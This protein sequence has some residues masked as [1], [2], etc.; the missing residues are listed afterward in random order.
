L[1]SNLPGILIL[2]LFLKIQ[3]CFLSRHGFWDKQVAY[4][5]DFSGVYDESK[6][7]ELIPQISDILHSNENTIDRLKYTFAKYGILFG[8]VKK[9]DGA[10]NDGYSHKYEGYPGNIQNQDI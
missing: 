4:S 5:S 1:G 6:L 3:L 8:V 10:S 2:S 9:V 7:N